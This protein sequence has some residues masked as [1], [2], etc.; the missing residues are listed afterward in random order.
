MKYL[1]T[2]A[3]TLSFA[4]FAQEDEQSYKYQPEANKAEYYMGTFNSKIV[5]EFTPQTFCMI[6]SPLFDCFRSHI[7]S[8]LI[9]TAF[10][11]WPGHF[12]DFLIQHWHC[13]QSKTICD[14]WISL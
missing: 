3:L 9:R 2:L 7:V 5:A 11:N 12:P 4:I 1:F 8:I 6:P 14:Q 10:K 13:L